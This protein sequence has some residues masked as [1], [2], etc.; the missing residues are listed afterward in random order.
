[1]GGVEANAGFGVLCIRSREGEHFVV[2]TADREAELNDAC[3][4]GDTR[5]RGVG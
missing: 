4:R 5:R 1:V 3:A 2:V